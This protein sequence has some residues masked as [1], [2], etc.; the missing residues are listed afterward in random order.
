M[1]KTA[2]QIEVDEKF[3]GSVYCEGSL[4]SMNFQV[5]KVKKAGAAVSNV[6]K[7][8]I[9]VQFGEEECECSIKNKKT[10]KKVV[11]KQRSGSYIINVDFVKKVCDDKYETI[12]KEVFTV[13]SGAEES[14]CPLSWGETFGLRAVEQGH[15]MRFNAAG[16]SMQH[17]SSIKVQFAATAF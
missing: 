13:Y 4:M 14:V 12:G 7:A 2:V 11:L 6:F 3:I 1:E 10:R 17:Y 5:S 15:E 9:I 16:D 8:G